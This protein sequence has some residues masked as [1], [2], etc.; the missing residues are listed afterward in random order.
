MQVNS[1][2]SQLLSLHSA[3]N[4]CLKTSVTQWLALEPAQKQELFKQGE[5]EFCSTE[6]KQYLNFMERNVP[7]EYKNIMRLE[8]GNF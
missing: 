7:I 1:V 3:Y 4:S 2:Q 6:K 8:E 5:Q